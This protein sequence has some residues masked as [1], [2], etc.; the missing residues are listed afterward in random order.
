[1]LDFDSRASA[2]FRGPLTLALAGAAQL[3]AEK[4]P[5]LFPLRERFGFPVL[6]GNRL[7]PAS[8]IAEQ[9]LARAFAKQA[10]LVPMLRLPVV[11]P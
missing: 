7:L 3:E 4:R 11:A 9:N 8:L 5:G 1:M 10:S 6:K 2:G